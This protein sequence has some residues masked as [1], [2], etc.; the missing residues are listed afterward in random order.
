MRVTAVRLPHE[1]WDEIVS[2]AR[3]EL[4]PASSV[5]RRALVEWLRNYKKGVINARPYRGRKKENI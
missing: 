5:V 4:R 2:I 3:E 1:V